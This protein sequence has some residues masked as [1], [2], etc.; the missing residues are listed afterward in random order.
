[1]IIFCSIC[2]VIIIILTFLCKGLWTKILTA[3][4]AATVMIILIGLV[5]LQTEISYYYD[6]AFALTLLSFIGTQFFIRLLSGNGWCYVWND[7]SFY[8][9]IY[10]SFRD[11]LFCCLQG[12]LDKIACHIY[13]RQLWI[14][15]SYA[16]SY[17]KTWI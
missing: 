4:L 12:F 8:W 3:N 14:S 13:H 1:M 11:F 6:I 2:L 16:G 7:Y 17:Y 5:A 15:N 9:F 10:L